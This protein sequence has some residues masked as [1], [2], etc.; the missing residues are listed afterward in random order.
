MEIWKQIIGYEEFYEISNLGNVRSVE[1]TIK[2]TNNNITYDRILRKQIIKQQYCNGYSTVS[3]CKDG[4]PK[5]FG[6]HRLVAEAF[7]EN[8]NN[9][10]QVNHKDE[11]RSNNCVDN[12]EWCDCQYNNSYG[13]RTEAIKKRVGKYTK[14]NI[15]ICVYDS[16]TD[17]EKDGYIGSNISNCCNGNRKFHKNFIW[18]F[19]K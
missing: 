15:L 19:I 4:K 11:N 3:L 10:P 18:K 17:A 12:L 16:I 9:L 14:E 2:Q 5:R 7:I 6:V 13:H 1:R 8:P